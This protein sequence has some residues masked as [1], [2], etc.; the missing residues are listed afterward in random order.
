MDNESVSEDEQDTGS[1]SVTAPTEAD[2]EIQLITEVWTEP[3]DG[4]VVSGENPEANFLSGLS[5]QEIAGKFFP[6]DLECISTLITFEHLCLMCQ[7]PC[8]ASPPGRMDD[9][10]IQPTEKLVSNIVYIG[11]DY[12]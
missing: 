9:G 3:Q 8:V 11:L 1:D 5:Q 4:K 2:G 7:N 10:Q 12:K 6:R